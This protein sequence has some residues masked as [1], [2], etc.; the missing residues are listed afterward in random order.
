MR[1]PG[2][3]GTSDLGLLVYGCCWR[4]LMGYFYGN[5]ENVRSKIVVYAL[6]GSIKRAEIKKV[7]KIM[8]LG[9]KILSSFPIR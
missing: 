4:T 9:E 5:G 2:H 3:L 7:G 1:I 8:K 6:G